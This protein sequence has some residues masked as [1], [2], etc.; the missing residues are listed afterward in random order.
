MPRF[1]SLQARRH[2]A[3]RR[4]AFERVL[5]VSEAIESGRR[6]RNGGYELTFGLLDCDSSQNSAEQQATALRQ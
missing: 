4:A 3:L 5:E 6:I 1:A 2:R